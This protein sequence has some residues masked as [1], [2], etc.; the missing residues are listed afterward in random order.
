MNILLN[1]NLKKDEKKPDENKV[2]TNKSLGTD[3]YFVNMFYKHLTRCYIP[4]T[5]KNEE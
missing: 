1:Y 4:F 3:F 2:V 5:E